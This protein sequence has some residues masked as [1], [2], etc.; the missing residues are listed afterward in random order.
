MSI[1]ENIICLF[2]LY[3]KVKNINLKFL[4]NNDICV[5]EELNNMV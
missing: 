2:L 1:E 4:F 5:F 3:K